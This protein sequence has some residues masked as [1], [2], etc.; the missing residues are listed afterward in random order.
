MTNRKKTVDR[1]Q[2]RRYGVVPHLLASLC[3]DFSVVGPIIDISMGGLQFRYVGA[4]ED[5]QGLSR[6]NISLTDG[7]FYLFRVPST[8]V[9]ECALSEELSFDGVAPRY[10]G[11][12]FHD[13]T[14]TQE[15]EL[16]Y[17]IQRYTTADDRAPLAAPPAH[18][19]KEKSWLRLGLPFL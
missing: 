6:L 15:S 17:L 11:V 10:C 2:H 16:R 19:S 5:V 13:L 9:W 12:K 7:S 1:R 3:P 4:T 14:H 18:V 8:P